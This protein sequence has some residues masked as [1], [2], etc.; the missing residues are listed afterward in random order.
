MDLQREKPCGSEFGCEAGLL[1]EAIK[2]TETV[3]WLM[4]V[5]KTYDFV[6]RDNVMQVMRINGIVV[7]VLGGTVPF[8]ICILMKL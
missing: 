8:G 4:D 3:C 2:E 7:F 5:E 1:K 6:K